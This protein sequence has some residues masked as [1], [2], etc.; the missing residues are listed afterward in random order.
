[1]VQ[2]SFHELLEHVQ[3]SG[4]DIFEEGHAVMSKPPCNDHRL[5][6]LLNP[7]QD[8]ASLQD[9]THLWRCYQKDGFGSRWTP[10]LLFTAA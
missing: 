6:A 7:E 9:M 3:K 10:V 1:M 4:E 2:C 8:V 5:A